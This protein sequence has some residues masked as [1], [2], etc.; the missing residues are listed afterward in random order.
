MK[1]KTYKFFEDLDIILIIDCMLAKRDRVKRALLRKST[2][3]FPLFMS[4][5]PQ[6]WKKWLNLPAN[7]T[8]IPIDLVFQKLVATN[9]DV[10]QVGH[11]A[12]YPVRVLEL[13][14]GAKYEDAWHRTH[15]ISS[16][17][18][19]FTSPFPLQP[20]TK[21]DL[22]AIRAAWKTYSFPDL[23][24]ATWFNAL[25]RVVNL[26][27]NLEDPLSVWGVINGPFEP[28]WQLL[29]DGWPAFFVLYRRDPM[30]AKEILA[31]VTDVC[32]AAGQ[33][34]IRHGVEAIRIGDDYALNEGPMCSP[35][36][37]HDVIYP[38][39]KR[40]VAGLKAIGG[41]DFPVIL[42]S[43]G[44][45][46]PLL[47]WL[48][49]GGLDA[50]NP[51]QPD[52]LDFAQVTE[53]I[54]SKLS[55]TAAFDLRYFLKEFSP[56]LRD[57]MRAEIIR[58]FEIIHKY[59]STNSIQEQTNFCIGPTHQVQPGSFVESYDAWIDLVHELNS[60]SH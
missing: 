33:A 56:E 34:M 23:T 31:K 36:T 42:H 3:R 12:F 57:Q 11:P 20:T 5:T 6:F 58:L 50:I 30:L 54:G 39:H 52:A 32:I 17:Y 41:Q 22:A 4:A 43:D 15:I 9:F 49:T 24:S 13:P 53:K 18:D 45:I 16:F 47:D 51:I 26:N 59:N 38:E 46:M 14:E 2:D 29:S 35:Q 10:I 48:G 37:W 60:N 1:V 55:L 27:K 19:N 7:A 44:N 8:E 28:T 40:L 25:D 21:M